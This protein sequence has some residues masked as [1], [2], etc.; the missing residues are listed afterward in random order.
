MNI[1]TGHLH[2][3]ASAS[4]TQA[5]S[6]STQ[7]ATSSTQAATSSAATDL[8]APTPGAMLLIASGQP[9]VH[10]LRLLVVLNSQVDGIIQAWLH[11]LQ[12]SQVASDR[13]AEQQQHRRHHGKTL[14]GVWHKTQSSPMDVFR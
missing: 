14:L 1:E 11:A 6:S 3:Q 7:A 9:S 12:L 13:C 5:V 8:V 10:V 4:S 2:L